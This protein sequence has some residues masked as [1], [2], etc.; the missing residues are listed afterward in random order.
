[1]TVTEEKIEALS[2]AMASQ[3]KVLLTGMNLDVKGRVLNELVCQFIVKTGVRSD[4]WAETTK[5]LHR[6]NELETLAVESLELF[7]KEKTKTLDLRDF[8][9]RVDRV[10]KRLLTALVPNASS[11]VRSPAITTKLNR[12]Q[13][14]IEKPLLTGRAKKNKKSKVQSTGLVKKVTLRRGRAATGGNYRPSKYS[15]AEGH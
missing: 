8:K 1:M 14:E 15:L 11:L 13:H 5:L 3:V 2:D 4:D 7:T 10:C 6:I 12:L 9:K